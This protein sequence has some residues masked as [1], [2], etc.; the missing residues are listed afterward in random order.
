MIKEIQIQNFKC[1]QQ[2]ISFEFSQLN[3]LTGVNGRGKSSLL[4]AFLVLSQSAWQN[5]TLKKL[6]IN[7]EL[8]Q[9]GNFDDIKNSETP[10]GEDIKFTFVIATP[11]ISQVRIN[12]KENPEDVL[13]ADCTKFEHSGQAIFLDLIKKIHFVSADRLGP[14]KYVYK[15]LNAFNKQSHLSFPN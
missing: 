9:L 6:I 2:A 7:G 8:L 12:Y 4:Q 1:F 10:R 11:N 5:A 14:L 15:T 3:L 13:I